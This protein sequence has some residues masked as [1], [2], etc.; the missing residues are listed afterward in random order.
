M[1]KREK[2]RFLHEMMCCFHEI[3]YWVF[4]AAG[5]LQE[6]TFSNPNI[7]QAFFSTE[8]PF[9][10][11]LT[12]CQTH[13]TPVYFTDGLSMTWLAAPEKEDGQ[14]IRIHTFGP[15]FAD[16]ASCKQCETAISSLDVSPTQREEIWQTFRTIPM[17]FFNTLTQRMVE[18]HDCLTGQRSSLAD[19]T[20]A[21][22]IPHQVQR[23]NQE[24]QEG[25]RRH[26][27]LELEMIRRIRKGDLDY[28]KCIDPSKFAGTG[29]SAYQYETLRQ[30]KN[31]TYAR[32]GLV[33]EAA[34]AGGVDPEVALPLLY[35]HLQNMEDATNIAELGRAAAMMEEEFAQRVY[36]RR[37]SHLS[38][39]ILDC[40]DYIQAHLEDEDLTRASLSKILNYSEGYLSRKFSQEMDTTIK[41]YI[42]GQRLERAKE[43][44][45]TT[46]LSIQ[47]ISARLHFGTHSHFTA[48]FKKAYGISPRQ[49]RDME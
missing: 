18:L 4:D 8:K 45:K 43:L 23:Q 21:Q 41:D 6:T 15:S 36:R 20:P 38:K 13:E 2:V 19:L 10:Q 35:H 30:T 44:L 32:A 14:L 7:L 12:H 42:T 3:G 28:R 5:T 47:D 27:D 46:K 29:P 40:C 26:H 11:I 49:W 1:D 17:V 48:A 37:T 16:N 22:E 24:K 31:R 9:Q 25:F 34:I 33:S 39:T